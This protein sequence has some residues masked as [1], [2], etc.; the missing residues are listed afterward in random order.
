MPLLSMRF[1]QGFLASTFPI[2]SYCHIKWSSQPAKPP[3]LW[4]SWTRFIFSM[5]PLHQEHAPTYLNITSRIQNTCAAAWSRRA[6]REDLFSPPPWQALP[7][8]AHCQHA[9]LADVDSPCTTGSI[10]L[11]RLHIPQGVPWDWW[12][13]VSHPN[14]THPNEH[15]PTDQLPPTQA[16]QVAWTTSSKRKEKKNNRSSRRSS[17]VPAR[18]YWWI[19]MVLLLMEK[20]K[21]ILRPWI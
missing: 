8:C 15:P 6:V 7:V 13:Q 16:N 17:P 4:H 9:P 18:I 2:G 20:M 19:F 1:P 11:G 14:W 21:K 10:S 12:S 3:R 5:W